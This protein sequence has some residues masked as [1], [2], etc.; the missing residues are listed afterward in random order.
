MDGALLAVRVLR[1]AVGD[2]DRSCSPTPGSSVCQSSAESS[3]VLFID[4]PA[5]GAREPSACE[6]VR[7][8]GIV[9]DATWSTEDPLPTRVPWSQWQLFP[10]LADAAWS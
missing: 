9:E 5:R 7:S 1:A 2:A 3:V 4:V 8:S 10:M 6:D